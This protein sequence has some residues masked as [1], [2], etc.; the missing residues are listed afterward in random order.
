LSDLLNPFILNSDCSQ[1]KITL[2]SFGSYKNDLEINFNQ[3]FRPLLI[4]QLIQCCTIYSNDVVDQSFFW[5]LSV[6]KRI[7][8]LLIIS[9]SDN[10]LLSFVTN[11]LNELCKQPIEITI[12]IKDLVNS[13]DKMDT[14]NQVE[15]H[16]DNERFII[17]KPTGRDQIEWLNSSFT[18]E[19]SASIEIIKKLIITDNKNSSDK[20]NQILTKE[21]VAAINEILIKFDPLIDFHAQIICP[22]CT[23]ANLYNIDL[24]EHALLKLRQN[25]KNLIESIHCI[26]L[27]YHWNEHEILSL[28]PWRRFQ[29]I[30][31]I[32]KEKDQ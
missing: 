19:D 15:F 25:Q 17:R 10:Y 12:P 13:H 26:A 14:D 7:E 18:D 6:G 30:S 23:K 29:Y 2:R 31:L 28:P 1:S 3:K 27:H 24:E 11:C 9:S 32:K 16:L 8:C 20:L 5:N 21:N 22:Y 4:T